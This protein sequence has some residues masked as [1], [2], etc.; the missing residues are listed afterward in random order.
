MRIL[1]EIQLF[2]KYSMGVAHDM[3]YI[4]L[5]RYPTSVDTSK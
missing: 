1:L 3:C 4:L 5:C 2:L